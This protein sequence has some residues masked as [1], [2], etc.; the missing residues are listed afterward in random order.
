M[1]LRDLYNR[2]PLPVKAMY[3]Y[4]R[5][6]SSAIAAIWI[7]D[8]WKHD[9]RVSI[10]KYTYGI[11]GSRFPILTAGTR[12][13]IGK[14]CSIAQHVLFVVGRHPTEYVSTFPFRARFLE[15]GRACDEEIIQEVI[16]IGNDVWIGTRATIMANVR[17]GHGAVVA[18]GAVVVKDVPPYAV[19]AG[20]PAK[21][22]KMRFDPDQV[23]RL[24]EIA[25]WDW[26]DERIRENIDLFYGDPDEF[27][28][29]HSIQNG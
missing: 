21:V 25:W 7:A 24:L 27:I 1:M 22:V 3:R 9:S 11:R 17:I 23:E 14:F 15:G 4:V 2:L 12:I 6:K 10:G 26:P 28:R 19:V 29:K 5:K 20:V 18:A 16:T 13:E 8:E